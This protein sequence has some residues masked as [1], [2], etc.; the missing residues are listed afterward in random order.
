MKMK[1]IAVLLA[2]F[3]MAISFQACGTKT[4]YVPQEC[5]AE[6]PKVP[7][8]KEYAVDDNNLSRAKKQAA[9]IDTLA[10]YADIL[11]ALLK[12]CLPSK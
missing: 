11:R 8:L 3:G 9:N 10:E 7:V 12:S 1:Q 4:V 2:T 5:K 6:M